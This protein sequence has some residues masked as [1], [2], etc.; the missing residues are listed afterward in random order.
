MSS[1]SIRWSIYQICSLFSEPNKTSARMFG[2]LENVETSCARRF[3]DHWRIY[4]RCDDSHRKITCDL[5]IAFLVRRPSGVWTSVKLS[6]VLHR[7]SWTRQ[8]QN[9]SSRSSME[10]SYGCVTARET[11]SQFQ[12]SVNLPNDRPSSTQLLYLRKYRVQFEE[13]TSATSLCICRQQ[14]HGAMHADDCQITA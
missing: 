1:I 11:S 13:Y 4:Q 7:Y 8:L 14:V 5:L 9:C 10:L 3:N 12:H 6:G 2:G